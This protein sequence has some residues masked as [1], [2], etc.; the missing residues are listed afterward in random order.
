MIGRYICLEAMTTLTLPIDDHSSNGLFTWYK[1]GRHNLLH[2]DMYAEII[3][4]KAASTANLLNPWSSFVNPTHNL[5]SLLVFQFSLDQITGCCLT[6]YVLI[7]T[8]TMLHQFNLVTVIHV[9][10]QSM[11]AEAGRASAECIQSCS[12]W[13]IVLGHCRGQFD[14]SRKSDIQVSI[15]LREWRWEAWG[16]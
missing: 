6:T 5:L 15:R 1:R 9:L 10:L 2:T 4:R 13:S 16:H 14:P 11:L 7:D 3:S 8:L 12:D